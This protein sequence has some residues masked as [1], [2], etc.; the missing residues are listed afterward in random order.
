MHAIRCPAAPR[1]NGS[2][3]SLLQEDGFLCC[4]DALCAAAVEVE[5]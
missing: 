2:A 5:G 4:G 1:G 3:F